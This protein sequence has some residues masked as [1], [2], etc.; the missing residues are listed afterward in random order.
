MFL[1][2]DVGEE[3]RGGNG[4]NTGEEVAR[5][6]VAACCGGGVGPVGGDH[7]VNCGHI[8]G[9]VSDADNSGEDR[10]A[11]PV[12]WWASASPCKTDE[13]DWEA[14][15]GV[16]EEP[17]AGFILCF[18]VLGLLFPFFDVASDSGNECEPGN[19]VA[20]QNWEEREALGNGSETPLGVDEGEGLDE[21]EN[22]GVREPRQEG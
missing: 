3:G 8:D 5:P 4:E 6:A 2:A 7:V 13:T 16:E 11:N 20:D 21:H 18:F 15:R 22:Q 12:D 10:G 14:R 9:V 19:E 17:E 1:P